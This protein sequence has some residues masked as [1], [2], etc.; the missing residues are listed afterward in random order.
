M[1]RSIILAMVVLVAVV[2]VAEAKNRPVKAA[3]PVLAVH[4][5]TGQHRH[6]TRFANAAVGVLFVLAAMNLLI[7]TRD[8]VE[9]TLAGAV[10]RARA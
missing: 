10:P 1:I 6:A 2:S 5:D 8:V 3:K 4:V 9:Q 7:A